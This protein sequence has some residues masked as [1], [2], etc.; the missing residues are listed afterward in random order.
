[1]TPELWQRVNE[2][3]LH[4]WDV[5]AGNRAAFLDQACRDEPEL[6]SKVESLLA[7][8]ERVGEFLASPAI[9][10]A[11]AHAAAAQPDAVPVADPGLEAA[12]RIPAYRILR[13]I[14]HGGMGIV[15][16]A[17][18][19]DGLYRKRVAVKVVNTG[20]AG[21]ESLRRFR[22]ERQVAA[23]LDHPNIVRLLDGGTTGDGLPYLV[24]EYVDGLR[25][26]RWCDDR[27]TPVRER[28]NLIRQVCA[29]VQYAHDKGVI[30][31][32]IKPGNILVTNTG[33]PKLL[34][35]G[36]A[37]VLNPE[38]FGDA[39]TTFGP[40]PM[41]PEYASPEQM[42][43]EAVGPASDVYA[44]GTVVYY[45]LT[46]Q[47]QRPGR[48][49]PAA[50]IDDREPAKPSAALARADRET[51][52]RVFG[53]PAATVRRQLAGDLDNVVLRALR[54]EPKKRYASVA[55]F[56]DDIGRFLEG[57]PVEA[58]PDSLQYRCL[59]FLKRN[60]VA[61]MSAV[62]AAASVL[63]LVGA[64]WRFDAR[65]DDTERG[66]RSIAVLPLENLSGDPD[67]EY[68]ADGITD[69]LIGELARL[70]DLRVT[71]RTSV[72]SFK[73]ARRPLSQIARSLGVR[74]V[75]EGS[76]RR[77]G[78][79]VRISMRLVDAVSDRS[80]WS[81]SYEGAMQD[82]L[83]LEE[84]VAA[85]IAGEIHVM[86]TAADRSRISRN[87]RINLD[88]YDAYLKGRHEYFSGYT[89]ASLEKAIAYFHR[90]LELDPGYAPAFEG[91]AECYW[92]LSSVYY[93]PTDVMPKAKWAAQ[94]A[95]ELDDTEGEAHGLL[96][97]VKSQFEFS[98]QEADREFH[99]ALDLKPSDAQVH[100]WYS[101]HLAEIGRFDAALEESEQAQKLDP[102][103]PLVSTYLGVTLFLARRYDELIQRMQPF[104][105]MDP[106]QQQAHAFLA[107]AYEQ[108][109]QYDDAIR[110]ME[111]AYELDKDQ[112]GLAQLGHMYAMSGRTADARKVLRQLDDPA[113]WRYVSAYNIGVLHAGLGELDEAFRWLQN[114]EQDRSEWF[115]AINV[116]PRLDALHADTRFAGILRKVG[117]AH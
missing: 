55:Q 93:P 64:F 94:K 60:R 7:A 101:M 83:S 49:H 25:I 40:A 52:S 24:M 66:V 88:A 109:G 30:H 73:R 27:K 53:E 8:D 11:R 115:A 75:A 18:R 116:D 80:I 38:L 23:S 87:R 84:R 2:I 29:A 106:N 111:R 26:D 50:A 112:D 107:L 117:L 91:M 71:S 102:V 21:E 96:G 103:S 85:S 86:L 45:L 104:I 33:A 114:V 48:A 31:R 47:V 69:A 97:M 99:R 51:V 79:R 35:F 17:E 22:T 82:V 32:D 89:L 90:A 39:E 92:G 37:K 105:A 36:V 43:G 108:K 44:L 95:I 113:R 14:A 70:R 13:E 74:T 98:R 34:D 67:Q 10:L 42:R 54:S 100:L 46:G 77:Y 28:L 81:G 78:N 56:S 3:V 6:R 9:E 1:M 5:E 62:L 76:V 65:H 15:Y 20:M 110:E 63:V 68:F 12:P 72:L 58:H 57:R 61:A 19:A 59:K 4:A 16:L 41:T